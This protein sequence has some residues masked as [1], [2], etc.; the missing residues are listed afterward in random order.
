MSYVGYPANTI[1]CNHLNFG[2]GGDTM[3]LLVELSPDVTI[4]NNMISSGNGGSTNATN[5]G[6]GDVFGVRLQASPTLSFPFKA[7]RYQPGTEGLQ[8]L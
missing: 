1:R 2:S 6:G 8:P 7:T 3:A 5:G 4:L